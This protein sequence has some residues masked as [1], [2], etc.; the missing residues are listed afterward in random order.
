MQPI[1]PYFLKIFKI[2]AP[3]FAT[4]C[5]VT[6]LMFHEVRNWQALP[7]T[8]PMQKPV[9]HGLPG[10]YHHSSSERNFF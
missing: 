5:S 4:A 6:A 8:W 2:A 7:E 9:S 10:D 1:W 3:W